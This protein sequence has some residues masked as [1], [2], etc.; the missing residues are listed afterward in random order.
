MIKTDKIYFS[1][2]SVLV[3]LVILMSVLFNIENIKNRRLNTYISELELSNDLL[4]KENTELCDG[5]EYYY[6]LYKT[7]EE[8]EYTN[9]LIKN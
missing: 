9:P 4:I 7:N 3:I 8:I 5:I 1:I 6:R 2:I